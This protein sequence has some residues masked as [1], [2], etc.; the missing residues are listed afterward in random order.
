MRR[1][2][3]Q[4]REHQVTA[5]Q[6]AQRDGGN[7]RTGRRE[8]QHGERRGDE[9]RRERE[10]AFALPRGFLRP[11]DEQHA[12]DER[13]HAGRREAMRDAHDAHRGRG[14]RVGAE[15]IR[16]AIFLLVTAYTGYVKKKRMEIIKE[17]D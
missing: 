10:D 8:A 2:G 16:P 11:R 5:Q 9:Q 14:Q 3:R 6:I 4:Q 15:S 7:L 17:D 13:Q 12:D 1:R